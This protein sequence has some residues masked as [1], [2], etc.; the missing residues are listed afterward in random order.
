MITGKK[1]EAASY[2]LGKE[3]IYGT[4]QC[5]LS[6]QHQLEQVNLV[7]G[8]EPGERREGRLNGVRG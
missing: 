3:K 7:L 1:S 4:I 5:T 6:E 2:Q 8:A